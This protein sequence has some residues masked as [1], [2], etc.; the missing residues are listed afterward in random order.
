MPP[1]GANHENSLLFLESVDFSVG[2][3]DV[4]NRSANSVAK[5]KLAF[6][7]VAPS[8]AGRVFKVR[9]V[10]TGPAVQPIDHHFAVHGARDFDATVLHILGNGS[11][12]PR[13][14]PG[15]RVLDKV[16][17]LAR[18][19]GHCLGFAG[20]EQGAAPIVELA[21]QQSDETKGI[22]RQDLRSCLAAGGMHFDVK[23]F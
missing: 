2:W 23:A 15:V 21:A 18:I 8:G 17:N 9:H 6:H 19:V 7:Q 10:D 1:S 3:V 16:G 5:I 11:T 22:R 13:G 14:V 12:F 4:L 20:L